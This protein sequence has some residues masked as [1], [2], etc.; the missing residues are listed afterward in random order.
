MGPR[1]AEDADGNV[2]VV[3]RCPGRAR[4]FQNYGRSSLWTHAVAR[5][6]EDWHDLPIFFL[7]VDRLNNP[8]AHPQHEPSDDPVVYA[9]EPVRS[10]IV[11][12]KNPF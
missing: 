6:L 3:I 11:C 8:S 1:H 12:Q 9:F 10:K 4:A 2:T 7:K 5:R